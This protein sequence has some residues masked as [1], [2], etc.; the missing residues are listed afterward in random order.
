[1]LVVFA[2]GRGAPAGVRAWRGGRL[3]GDGDLPARLLVLAT[4]GLPADRAEWGRAMQA[5]LSG[6]LDPRA[7][8]L[9]SLGCAH[10]MTRMRLR[11][12]IGLRDGRGCGVRGIVLSAIVAV[13]ALG[14]FGLVRYPSL[15][16]GVAAW[17]AVAAFL[18]VLAAYAALA[19]TL[20]HGA[21]RRAVAARR[22]GLC[23]GLA[24]GLAW[25]WILAPDEISK[26]LVFVPLGAALLGPVCTAA[27][28]RR[29]GAGDR[30]ATQ[31][32]LWSGMT[33]A[34]LAFIVWVA[35]AYAR[36]GGP[37]D[38]Q[39]VRDFHASGSHDLAAYAVGDDL[40][41]ALGLLV[42]VPLLALALGS[43]RLR[44]VPR[45]SA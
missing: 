38:A 32:A 26:S 15:H 1:V 34:L 45:R 7:R 4:R 43:L 13:L 30:A 39:L 17:A 20:S 22:H 16:T 31:A 18:T 14:L 9:F 8:L 12:S 6:V 37:Y 41:A 25:L 5:E 42:I 40:G 21:G 19:L 27:L 36:D 3:E 35:A 10:A 29:S 23:G 11:A 44:V 33:G 2:L 24:V 28:V